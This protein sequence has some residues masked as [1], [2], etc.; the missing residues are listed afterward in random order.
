ML[1]RSSPKPKDYFRVQQ[2]QGVTV[3]ELSLPDAMDTSEFDRLN[4][5]ILTLFEG[6][7]AGKWVV[8]LTHVSYMGSS[9]L[10]LMVNLRQRIKSGGGRL[11]LCCLSPRLWE[12]FRT[13]CM[14]RLFTIARTRDE[15]LRL[16]K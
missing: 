2:V 8:D 13:C 4:D 15:A 10:G 3:L 9:T 5:A 6:T 16:A 1:F 12:I 7:A 14:E 11:V